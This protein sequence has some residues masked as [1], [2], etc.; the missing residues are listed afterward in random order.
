MQFQS[1]NKHFKIDNSKSSFSN[2]NKYAES[3]YEKIDHQLC[4]VEFPLT[5]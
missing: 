5:N 4:S 2:L 1:V 3:I